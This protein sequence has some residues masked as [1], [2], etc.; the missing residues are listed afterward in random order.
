M[1]PLSLPLTALVLISTALPVAAQTSMRIG[2]QQ[3]PTVLDPTSDATAAIDVMLTQNVYESL[4]TVDESGAVMPQLAESWTISEDGLTYT[5]SLVQG[6]TFH[7][8]SAFDAQ[9][10]V[11][12]FDRARAE[13]SVNPTSGIWAPIE[14]VSA[15]GPYTIEITLSEPDA[16]F[17][18][19]LAQGD[20]SIVAPETVD[21]NITDPVGT[22]PFQF[23]S[24]T[25]GDR[26]TLTAFDGH[27]DAADVG[28]E[29]VE[30]RFIS[31]PAAATAALLAEE[32]DAFPGFPA[33]ELI[34]QF[35]ADPRFDVVLGS[36]EGEVILALN[37]SKPP[38]DQLEVRRAVSH[39]IDR[40]EIIDGAMYGRATPIGSFYP[41]HGP[42][43]VDLTSA[44]PHDTA[45]ATEM[46]AQAGLAEAEITLRLP[47]FPYATR[48]GEIIQAQMAE[49]G[50]NVAIE[51]V[52]WGFW[53]D[54]VF[55][56]KNYDMTIIA[57]TSPNDLANFARGPEY[58]YGFQSD[59]Y[60]AL[61]QQ[62]RTEADPEVRNTLLQDAQRYVTENAVHG[63]LF[64]L[65]RL[66]INKAGIT[67]FWNSSPVLFQPL[68][69]VRFE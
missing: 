66:S 16:F 50:I 27:R 32:L 39:A 60:D 51:N 9:D 28:L 23:D 58:F 13:G 25:R 12:S 1:R 6:V 2:L 40:G 68:A 33:P 35:E 11:F 63:F 41:P 7:D 38:F 65:P 14:S 26:L 46:F 20:A 36:T 30:F 22:G 64:Q 18:F 67:G 19:N 53:I 29:R 43:Y 61:W 49:A 31:D 17:L 8:G 3:E 47:P 62:I 42:A 69:G 45:R 48:S 10:V 44:Y 55:R 24:W 21:T 54:E 56:K 34:D 15:P 5:F 37:N 52:E 59:A 4:T 57:H